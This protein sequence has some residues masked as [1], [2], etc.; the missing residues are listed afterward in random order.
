MSR[1]SSQLA[2]LFKEARATQPVELHPRGATPAVTCEMA[3]AT[4]RSVAAGC[5]PLGLGLAMHLYP[6]CALR[7]VPL[8]W[9]S[10]AGLRRASLLRAIDR[11]GLI[12]AN[13]GSERVLGSPAPVR[14]TR[15]RGGVL[16]NGSFDYVSLANAADLVL[17]SAP[18]ADGVDLFCMA[19]MSAHTARVGP[20][21]FSGNMRLSDTCSVHFDNHLLERG[22]FVAIRREATLGCMTLYQRSWFHLLLVEC[23]LARIDHLRQRHALPRGIEDLAA[24]NELGLLRDYATRLLNEAGRP[25]VIE[26]LSRVTT[27]MKLRTS[28]MAEST[29]TA[30]RGMDDVAASELRHLKRQPA[31]DDR[32]IGALSRQPLVVHQREVLAIAGAY[33]PKTA[34]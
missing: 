5:L 6:L 16:L 15:V 27:A 28:W 23:Y 17:F 20:P 13:A 2:R 8:P 25:G 3:A 10:P 18:H 1:S 9:W 11:H 34:T 24:R 29:A 7:W 31:S 12:L 22:D 14:L 32:I 19:R 26:T 33:A 4:A 30:L 21:R